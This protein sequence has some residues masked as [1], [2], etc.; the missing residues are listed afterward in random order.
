MFSHGKFEQKYRG[1]S[2]STV[3]RGGRM[4][5]ALA[6]QL[7]HG[8]YTK[9][10]TGQL[11]VAFAND[12]YPVKRIADVADCSVATAK[13]WWEQRCA[14]EGLHLARLVAVVPE[15]AGEYRRITAMERDIDPELQRDM[16][17]LLQTASRI[18][19]G[20]AEQ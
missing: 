2:G 20:R 12:R 14:P 5:A 18:L 13:N 9:R 10:I 15:V 7:N 19:A 8:E 17:Q 16:T 1:V 6:F 4:N 11:R 3:L